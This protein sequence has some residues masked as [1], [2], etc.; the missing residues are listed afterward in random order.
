MPHPLMGLRWEREAMLPRY[1]VTTMEYVIPSKKDKSKSKNEINNPTQRMKINSYLFKTYCGI[2]A[3]YSVGF[4]IL[5]LIYHLQTF[6]RPKL[7]LLTWTKR[8]FTITNVVTVDKSL[9]FDWAPQSI[10]GSAIENLSLCFRGFA[11]LALLKWWFPIFPVL[12]K[13]KSAYTKQRL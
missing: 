7:F 12:W 1:C 4:F 6:D 5:C 8:K 10:T 11:V 2:L 3:G 9:D 13:I